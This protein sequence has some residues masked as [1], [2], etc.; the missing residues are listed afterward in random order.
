MIIRIFLMIA[1]PSR[2]SGKAI[3]HTKRVTRLSD[4]TLTGLRWDEDHHL[5]PTPMN[6]L[7]DFL[8]ST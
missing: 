1:R 6:I 8:V 4:R 7:T 3:F 2:M 5:G